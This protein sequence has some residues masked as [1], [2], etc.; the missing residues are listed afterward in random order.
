MLTLLGLFLSGCGGIEWFPETGVASFSFSP[1]SE[2]DVAAGST[3]TSSSVTLAITGIATASISVSGDASSKY[4]INGG[5]YTNAAGTV[6]NGDRV[7]VQHTASNTIGGSVS[8]TLTVGDKSATFS[9]MTGGFE[10]STAFNV[11]PMTFV[12]SDPVTLAVAG[13]SAAI[14]ISGD[15]SSLYSINGGTFTSQ[16][17]TVNN[18]DQVVVMHF[19]ADGATNTTVTSTLTVGG[20]SGTF[21]STTG[22]FA[23]ETVSASAS[24]DNLGSAQVRLRILD[25]PY[26]IGVATVGGSYSLNGT[27]YTDETATINLVDGQTLYLQGFAD[28]PAGTV[29]NYVFTLDGETAITFNIT[30]TN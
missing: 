30:T 1:A 5:S 6:K 16:A 26:E 8:S 17:G 4:S 22:N 11:D 13:G 3:R 12:E 29:T 15:E 2:V 7:T 24:A 20:K 25:G 14:S 21:V 23:R 27:D 19:S 18:G 10:F 28:P 9:S